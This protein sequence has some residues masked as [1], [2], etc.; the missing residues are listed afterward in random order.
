MLTVVLLSL[1]SVLF[2]L[3]TN[4]VL[5]GTRA[6]KSLEESLEMFYLAEAGLSHGQAFCVAYG[7]E[8]FPS[9]GGNETEDGTGWPEI[10]PPFDGWVPFGR[11]RYRVATYRLRLD[12]Q[13]FVEKDEGILL[14]AT[15]ELEGVGQ[16]RAFLLLDEPPSCEPLAWWEPP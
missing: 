12:E 10:D 8:W 13:P 7:D 5:L 9:L 11:G 4:S 1:L 14:V 3:A 16:K 15:A 6:R 2:L